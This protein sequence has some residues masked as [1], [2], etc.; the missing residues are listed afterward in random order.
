MI[1]A[2]V[3]RVQPLFSFKEVSPI[4]LSINNMPFLA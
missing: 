4:T 1:E 2:A 3:E